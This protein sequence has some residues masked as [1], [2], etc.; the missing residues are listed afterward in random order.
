MPLASRDQHLR[1]MKQRERFESIFGVSMSEFYFSIA[2]G[3]DLVK[4]DDWLRTNVETYDE[5]KESM[6]D[7]IVRRYGPEAATLVKGLI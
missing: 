2:V 6:G 7:F 4:F 3:F 1:I 5:D